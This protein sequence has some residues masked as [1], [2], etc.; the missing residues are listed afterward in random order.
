M[1]V[2]PA[3]SDRL[4]Q[5]DQVRLDTR[6]HDLGFGIAHADIVLDH[7]RLAAHVH[8]TDEDESL[9]VDPVLAQSL[10]GRL[11]DRPDHLAH[12]SLVG[13]RDRRHGAHAARI[14][15]GIS[16]AYALIVLG[17]GQY[18]IAFAVRRDENGTLDTRKVFLDHDRIAGMAETARQHL[19]E[20]P[21]RLFERRHDQHA[22]AGGQTV[23]LQHIGSLQG[24]Q[25]RVRLLDVLFGE[26][27]ITGRRNSVPRHEILSELLAT[28]QTRAE[29]G[30]PDHRDVADLAVLPEKVVYPAHQ[31]LLGPHDDHVDV[32]RQHELLDRAEIGRIDIDIRAAKGRSGIARSD[33]QARQALALCDLPCEGVLAPS[34]AQQENIG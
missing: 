32:V 33:E 10:D 12:E 34:G 6:K 28:L 24:L 30:R 13:E 14:G 27:A 11:D 19:S 2:E 4:E 8:Q 25:K 20:L 9:V 23:G 7:V 21:L 16:L 29:R 17:Y 15:S 5:I 3:E 22:L 31:R 1:P 18:T 26:T